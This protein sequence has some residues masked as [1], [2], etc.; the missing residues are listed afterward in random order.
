MIR[1]FRSDEKELY[2]TLT[3]EFY[4]SPATD[5][6]IP[7]THRENAWQEL[8]RPGG[9]LEACLLERQGEAAGYALLI[10]SFSQ[11]AGGPILWIDELYVRPAFR[12]QGLGRELFAWLAQRRELA[13]LRLEVE[14]DNFRAASLYRRLGFVPMPY[15]SMI[16]T[17]STLSPTPAEI[18]QE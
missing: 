6:P 10:R 11:E 13:G 4:A 7:D 17:G 15:R 3:R 9:L 2:F 12:G 5:H 18:H 16:N 14:P 1:P 8:R